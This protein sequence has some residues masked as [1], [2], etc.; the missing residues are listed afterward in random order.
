MADQRVPVPHPHLAT[1][2][3][4][5][6]AIRPA[7]SGHQSLIV[8]TKPPNYF[9]KALAALVR[10]SVLCFVAV[11]TSDPNPHPGLAGEVL[12]IFREEAWAFEWGEHEDTTGPE[13]ITMDGND[14]RAR[15]DLLERM[16]AGR[17]LLL[18]PAI[19]CLPAR[20]TCWEIAIFITS[21]IC[22]VP[23]GK[24]SQ[25]WKESDIGSEVT[26]SASKL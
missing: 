24:V 15:L 2:C 6:F 20:K 23:M 5:L 14:R 1:F 13:F 3:N 18:Y 10:S 19:D 7:H 11:G 16:R 12:R 21:E 4:G 26:A 17:S 25:V 22:K 8:A 9:E